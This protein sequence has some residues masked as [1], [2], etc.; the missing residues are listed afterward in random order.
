MVL[1]CADQGNQ[2]NIK[3]VT[4]RNGRYPA[5]IPEATLLS[6]ATASTRKRYRKKKIDKK[7]N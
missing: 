3:A 7:G 6:I 1:H 2:E 4:S 5:T